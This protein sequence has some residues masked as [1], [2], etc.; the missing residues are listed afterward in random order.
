MML[1][2]VLFHLGQIVNVLLFYVLAHWISSYTHVHPNIN[3]NKSILFCIKIL[4]II[5]SYNKIIFCRF[6]M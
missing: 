4:P 2:K 1:T 3:S 5:Y 6:K